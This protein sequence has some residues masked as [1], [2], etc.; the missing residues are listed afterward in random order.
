VEG[1]NN[2]QIA[3]QLFIS[4]RTVETHKTAILKKLDLSST[5]EP[6]KYALKNKII[7]L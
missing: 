1:M 4:V 3:D 7:E 5:V 2:R 6:V